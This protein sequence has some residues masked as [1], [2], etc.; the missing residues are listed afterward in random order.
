MPALAPATAATILPPPSS[1]ITAPAGK[2]TDLALNLISGSVGGAFQVMCGQP[3][4]TIKT[5]AQTAPPGQFKGPWDVA[6]QTVRK[7]G[8]L[9]LYKGA[10]SQEEIG[11]RRGVA[12]GLVRRSGIS[13][14]G[15]ELLVV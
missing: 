9:G 14:L 8:F 3:L 2:P 15:G 10:S 13:R 12:L 6:V 11:R 5:R 1:P 4:D 7:E